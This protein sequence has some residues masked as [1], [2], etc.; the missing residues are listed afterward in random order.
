MEADNKTRVDQFRGLMMEKVQTLEKQINQTSSN[1]N[2]FCSEMEKSIS[3][4]LSYKDKVCRLM[5]ETINVGL[6][7]TFIGNSSTKESDRPTNA[8][9]CKRFLPTYRF[10]KVYIFVHFLSC[11][12]F[13]IFSC[14]GGYKQVQALVCPD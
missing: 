10:V 13:L 4:F 11:A 1:Q 7:F 3:E 6:I 14:A 2:L 5:K 8:T 9:C 12:S